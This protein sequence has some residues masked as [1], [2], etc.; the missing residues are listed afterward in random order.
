MPGASL[1]I[2]WPPFSTSIKWFSLWQFLMQI[3]YALV[4]LTHD[5][6]PAPFPN[7]GVSHPL[8]KVSPSILISFFKKSGFCNERKDKMIFLGPACFC[9][10][11][12][13]QLHVLSSSSSLLCM[14]HII[15]TSSWMSTLAL[16][17]SWL[18]WI[19]L[20]MC[21]NP[22][23]QASASITWSWHCSMSPVGHKLLE[24]PKKYFFHP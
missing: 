6:L 20:P 7:P 14:I 2:L 23:T 24:N 10:R 22:W 8:P 19:V 9:E 1:A 17:M 4:V 16:S 18:L 12:N 13:L 21:A 5:P 11:D 3:Q 15:V